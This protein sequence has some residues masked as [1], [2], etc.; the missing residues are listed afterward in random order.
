MKKSS[1]ILQ[2]MYDLLSKPK[3]WTKGAFARDKNG[4]PVGY[5]S[6][7]EEAVSYCLLG[8]LT[9]CATDD[10]K[11]TSTKVVYPHAEVNK[12]ATLIRQIFREITPKT[13]WG[14]RE[15]VVT[16]NDKHSTRKKDVLELILK[17]KKFAL[18]EEK[19]KAKR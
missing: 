17:A 12:S 1:E 13:R 5:L 16:F 7:K 9:K 14:H 4:V 10:E 2:D 6:N 15:D 19:R 18:R 3:A 8:A 11:A